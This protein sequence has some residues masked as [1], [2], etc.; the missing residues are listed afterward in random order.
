MLRPDLSARRE[1]IDDTGQ[2]VSEILRTSRRMIDLLILRIDLKG[3]EFVSEYGVF[4]N[5]DA[6]IA[7]LGLHH[8]PA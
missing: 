5:A 8:Y 4:W 3:Y 6:T 7:L 2:G 1:T